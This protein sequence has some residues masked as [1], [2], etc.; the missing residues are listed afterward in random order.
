LLWL[1]IYLRGVT[2]EVGQ[3]MND[4]SAYGEELCIILPCLQSN[5]KHLVLFG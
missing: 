4:F 3:L 5:N 1:Q 2:M